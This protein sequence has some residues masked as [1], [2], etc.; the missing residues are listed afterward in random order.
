MTKG[1]AATAQARVTLEYPLFTRLPLLW[2]KLRK[3]GQVITTHKIRNKSDINPLAERERGG[4]DL[5]PTDKPDL[6]F[7]S[8]QCVPNLCKCLDAAKR[9]AREHKIAPTGQ[10]ASADRLPGMSA[11][12]D[13]A[14]QSQP[15]EALKVFRVVPGKPAIDANHPIR[16]DG[17]NGTTGDGLTIQNN[18]DCN[19]GR[20]R[21]MR[22]IAD[23]LKVLKTIIKKGLWSAGYGEVGQFHRLSS[24]LHLHLFEMIAVDMNI[25]S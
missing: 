6:T 19:R 25:T 4:I 20:Y 21:W 5:A 7:T 9:S 8:G 11:H 17:N 15:F 24:E 13:G 10:W 22:G 16:V 12:N 18:S 3:I 23:N 14:A 2:I 1:V